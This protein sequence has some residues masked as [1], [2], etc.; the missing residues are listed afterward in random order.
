MNHYIREESISRN[1]EIRSYTDNKKS[2]SKSSKV[3]LDKM[4]NIKYLTSGITKVK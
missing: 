1:L 2:N 3:T 4:C